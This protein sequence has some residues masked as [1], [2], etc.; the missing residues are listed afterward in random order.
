MLR[1]DQAHRASFQFP[2]DGAVKHGRKMAGG[3]S[4]PSDINHV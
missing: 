2:I 3:F 4:I 1:Q